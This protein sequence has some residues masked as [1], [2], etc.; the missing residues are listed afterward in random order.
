M[1][2]LEHDCTSGTLYGDW[3][4][5]VV[6]VDGFDPQLAQIACETIAEQSEE[7]VVLLLTI[8]CMRARWAVSVN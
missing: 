2:H 5:I 6:C 3:P 4:A 1:I 7:T 8:A